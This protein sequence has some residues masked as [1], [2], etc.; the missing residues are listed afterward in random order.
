[1]G[2]ARAAILLA[3]LL[4]LSAVAT[5]YAVV[6]EVG[7][8]YVSATATLQP[9]ELP[10]RGNAP[11]SLSSV[12]RVG[13]KDGSTPPTL[14][15]LLFL[16]DRH[17]T[18][19]SG[20][21]PVCTLAKLAETTPSQARKRCAGALVGKGTG[22]ALVSLPGKASFKISSPLSF[23]N[24]PP[25]GGRPTLIAHAFENVPEP[26]TLLVPFTIERVGHGR[27]GF[28]TQV[29]MPEVAGGYGA[30]ILAEATV[31]ATR[32]RHGKEVGYINAHCVGGRLQVY[33]TLRFTNGDFFPTTLTSPCHS[34][35]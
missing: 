35:G 34:P 1:M 3:A 2:R 21:W 9:R 18:I 29:E 22:K 28:R 12:T 24:G 31:G 11:V 4:A 23:F 7:P 5:A 6:A 10:K 14:K 26:K 27:Y 19:N 20:E 25:S 15:T 16:I 8:V 32:I 17:G 33:G 13:T 30:P